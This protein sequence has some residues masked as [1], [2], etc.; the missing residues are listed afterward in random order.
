MS[1][2]EVPRPERDPN[3][4]GEPITRAWLTQLETSTDFWNRTPQLQYIAHVAAKKKVSPWGLLAL[5]QEH[6]A[7]H[8]PPYVVLVDKE[9]AAGTILSDGTSLNGLVSLVARTGGGKSV[10]FKIAT[11][12][13]PPKGTPVPN[14]T[15]QGIMT[16]F[17]ESRTATKDSEGKPLEFPKK[18]IGFHRHS[19][20]IHA[21][22]VKTLN[23]EL[24]RDGSITDSL[25]RSLW[26]GE[27]VGMANA[28]TKRRALVPANVLRFS[29]IWGVQPVNAW[30]ILDQADDG[31]PQRFVWAPA[32]EYRKNPP[33]RKAPT[34]GV[35]FDPKCPFPLPVFTGNGS[36]GVSD[37][38]MP[39]EIDEDCTG[40]LPDPVWVTWSPQMSTD[41]AAL[42]AREAELFDRDPY[43]KLTAAQKA[44]ER[45][46]IMTSHFTLTTI[47]QTAKMGWIHG[48]PNPTDLDWELSQIQMQVSTRELAGVWEKCDAESLFRKQRKGFDQGIEHDA[49]KQMIDSI[50][51]GRIIALAEKIWAYLAEKPHTLPELK[52]R[53]S[54]KTTR[55]L[56]P[57]ALNWLRDQKRAESVATTGGVVWHA[58][59]DGKRVA[60]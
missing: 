17:V 19:A 36:F 47:K 8:I 57:V 43:A 55:D 52:P 12:L 13:I 16:T 42:Q 18:K 29:G 56:M 54:S 53:T 38:L 37:D 14:G 39:Q 26:V 33:A 25:L 34:P 41:I 49:R 45:E 6:Q 27:T 11:S 22:E 51:E 24:G 4:F 23:A 32:E 50:A 60:A 10:T 59:I 2:A 20:V 1:L 48:N 58:L 31:T 3:P 30:A 15:G 5:V 40:Q 28:D 7:S 44:A 21:A 9:G 35:T 46:L